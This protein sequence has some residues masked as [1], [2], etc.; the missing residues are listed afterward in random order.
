MTWTESKVKSLL[1]ECQVALPF[2]IDPFIVDTLTPVLFEV[3][4]GDLDGVFVYAGRERNGKSTL[5]AENGE[6]EAQVMARLTG[7][8]PGDVFNVT[9]IAQTADNYVH[10]NDI[11]PRKCVLQLDEGS[12]GLYGRRSMSKEN[13]GINEM[14]YACGINNHIH[15]ICIQ[16]FA[17]L[18]CDIRHRRVLGVFNVYGDIDSR[19]YIPR[20]VRGFADYYAGD[21]LKRIYIDQE[22]R[23]AVFPP[24]RFPSIKFEKHP[25]T[26]FWRDYKVGSA[27]A[28]KGIG[29]GVAESLRKKKK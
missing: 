27:E 19:D 26:Q 28:K 21:D 6:W 7:R 9:H 14:L 20:V 8:K 22:T 24:S 12:K 18:D 16:N 10:L 3:A 11:L 15:N 25:D 23:L 5:A 17:S 13:V 1:K 29:H 4:L 2:T